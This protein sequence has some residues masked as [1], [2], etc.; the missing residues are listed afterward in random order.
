MKSLNVYRE[1]MRLNSA[2]VKCAENTLVQEAEYRG[3]KWGIG[4][5][6]FI[7]LLAWGLLS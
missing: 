3:F 6:V 7:A 2:S 4:L 5:C 1:S